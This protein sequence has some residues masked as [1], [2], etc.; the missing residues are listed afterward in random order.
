[1]STLETNKTV[2]RRYIQEVINQ[3]QLDLIDTFFVPAMREKVRGF[4]TKGENPFPDGHEEILDIIAEGNTVMVR[5]LFK[6]THQG[7]FMGVP[8]TGKPVD[9]E[10]YGIYYLE[11]AQITWDTICFDWL[12]ALEQIGARVTSAD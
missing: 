12:E 7:T 5:W 4:L 1:M 9:V 3:R 6:A 11:N 8:A 2:V 10:G